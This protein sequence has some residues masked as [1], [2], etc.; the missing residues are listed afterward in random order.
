MLNPN[1][2][3]DMNKAALC[4]RN[5]EPQNA[6]DLLTKFPKKN[7]ANTIDLAY[8][9]IALRGI[10][11]FDEAEDLIN[12][13]KLVKKYYGQE[14]IQEDIFDFNKKFKNSLL[15]DPRRKIENDKSGW[16]IRGGTVIRGLFNDRNNPFIS[17][18]KS[19]YIKLWTIM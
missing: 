4:L 12:F 16:A 11:K 19:Y 5:N 8:K 7:P 18:F 2:D 14:L 10:G 17:K 9:T 6:L 3:L 15:L 1:F 13:P